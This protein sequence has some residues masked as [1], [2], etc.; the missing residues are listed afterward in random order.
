VAPLVRINAWRARRASTWG[1]NYGVSGPRGSAAELRPRIRYQSSR[2]RQGR[3][4]LFD[5]NN[6]NHREQYSDGHASFMASCLHDQVDPGHASSVTGSPDRSHMPGNQHTGSEIHKRGRRAQSGVLAQPAPDTAARRGSCS[7]AP[8]AT[9][10]KPSTGI[11]PPLPRPTDAVS[12]SHD[13][14]TGPV[15]ECGSHSWRRKRHLEPQPTTAAAWRRDHDVMRG[16]PCFP[17]FS[18]AAP[19]PPVL[20]IL[21]MQTEWPDRLGCKPNRNCNFT[22]APVQPAGDRRGG[23]LQAARRPTDKTT[24]GSSSVRAAATQA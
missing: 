12:P 7:A 24:T 9:K 18:L 8:R 13:H 14:R 5:V 10:A 11:V 3:L 16:S 15:C 17:A 2:N 4:P 1:S 23:S 19:A 6:V 20:C 21:Q 22:D